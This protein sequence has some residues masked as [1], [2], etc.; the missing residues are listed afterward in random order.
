M[1]LPASSFM[2]CPTLS[3]LPLSRTDHHLIPS[4]L[5]LLPLMLDLQARQTGADLPTFQASLCQHTVGGTSLCLGPSPDCCHHRLSPSYPS[6][7][8]IHIW[9]PF[10]TSFTID[11]FCT[12]RIY[13]SCRPS[14]L[15]IRFH[16]VL[17]IWAVLLAPGSCL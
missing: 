8:S 15:L 6:P 9:F 12:W 13:G 10:S 4:A 14:L 3:S 2:I 7:S 16:Y 5:C 11:R 1:P 17:K